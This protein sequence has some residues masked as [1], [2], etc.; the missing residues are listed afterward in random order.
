MQS[1]V[2]REQPGARRARRSLRPLAVPGIALGSCLLAVILFGVS[3][4]DDDYITFWEAE[5]LAKFGHLVNINGAAIE[6]S[7]SLAHVVVLA[8]LYFVTRVPI[9]VLSY[10]VGLAALA[11]TVWLASRL[12]KSLHPAAELP[13]ALVVSVAF[14]LV[15]WA[16]GGLETTL[17]AACMLWFVVRLLALLDG[18]ALSARSV[19]PFAASA[20]LVVAV[21]PDTMLVAVAVAAVALLAAA[22]RATR[23]RWATELLPEVAV[24]RSAL[25][26]GITIGA[27]ALLGAFRLVVFDSVLPQPE[28]AKAGGLAWLSVG[29]A[30]VATTL[31]WWLWAVLL[32]LFALGVAWSLATRSLPGLLA[33]ATFAAGTV[34]I[35]FTRGDWMGGARLLAPYLAPGL[36]VVVAGARCLPRWWRRGVLVGIVALECVVLVLFANGATWL[37]SAYGNGYAPT[38]DSAAPAVFGSPFGATVTSSAGQAPSLAW[39]TNWDFIHARDATFL[40]AATPALRSILAADT[41]PGKVTIASYQAGM[42]MYTWQNEFPGRLR[43]IDMDNIVTNDLS[44]CPGTATNSYTGQLIDLQQWWSFAGGCAPP[45]PDLVFFLGSPSGMSVVSSQYHVVRDVYMTYDQRRLLGH[46]RLLG[47]EEYLAVRNGW[48]P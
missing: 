40:A 38:L 35:M 29:Y 27:A 43:Y 26:V 34:A 33:A 39:Y 24:A 14:P 25:A 20:V 47:E 19:V 7:S 8:L 11:S 15:F 2:V 12:A 48:H 1:D 16:T 6:Q 18:A 22:V 5:Q 28:V 17:A 31:P 46:S 3:A 41:A 4:R 30:Y 32:V 9:P 45:L 42:I 23:L 13:A 36:V 44:K 37:S 10:L 21:R